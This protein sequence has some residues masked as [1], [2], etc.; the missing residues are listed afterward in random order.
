MTSLAVGLN[1]S[2]ILA[3]SN[4]F[5]DESLLPAGG[6][7]VSAAAFAKFQ[8]Q[9]HSGKFI[10]PESYELMTRSYTQIKFLWPDMSYGYGL[11]INREDGTT[12]YSHTG[13]LA[14]YM[15]M[16]LHYPEFNLDLVMLENLPLN[17]ND[18]NR[19][20]ELH[21]QI[22]QAIRSNLIISKQLLPQ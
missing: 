9:L 7:I 21:T 19:V 2:D 10:S 22:R 18:L 13:Y 11:R 16:S 12:E 4:L 17:L 5:I 3:P 14:G 6:L 1:E 8:H 15:S 20:F